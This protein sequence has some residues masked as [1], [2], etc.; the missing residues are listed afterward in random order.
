MAASLC[1]FGQKT[2]LNYPFYRDGIK[3]L[4]RSYYYMG[5]FDADGRSYSHLNYHG[6]SMGL[7]LDLHF[8][9]GI[10]MNIGAQFFEFSFI[11][12][13]GYGF[14]GVEINVDLIAHLD[15]KIPLS[16]DF[17]L[18]THTGL[19]IAPNFLSWRF[20]HDYSVLFLPLDNDLESF[21]PL[22]LFYGW[23]V[24][25]EHRRYRIELS[26]AIGLNDHYGFSP[27]QNKLMLGLV[28]FGFK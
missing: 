19:G 11:N 15:F 5:R 10:G 24:Y 25:M 21:Y 17:A 22:D 20:A 12:R 8:D 27:R 26:W 9:Y 4:G 28:Y 7:L 14:Y 23:A 18:G 1:S 13:Q 16:N 6:Y 2:Y 3:K